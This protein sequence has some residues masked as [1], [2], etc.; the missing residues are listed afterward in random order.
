[1]KKVLSIAVILIFSL[2]SYVQAQNAQDSAAHMAFLKNHAAAVFPHH[3]PDYVL[4]NSKFIIVEKVDKDPYVM[5]VQ[6][7]W[8]PTTI[9]VGEQ[10]AVF[11]GVYYYNLSQGVCISKVVEPKVV[12]Q[13]KQRKP[14]SQ[15]TKTA[16]ANTVT[17]VVGAVVNK[18]NNNFYN[19]AGGSF[20]TPDQLL[21]R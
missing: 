3:A 2:S 5:L 17:T 13:K 16:I 8:Q 21:P 11:N 20:Q 15:E 4:A 18:R 1:M 6:G 9:R 14:M 12:K 19:S 7:A 10:Y